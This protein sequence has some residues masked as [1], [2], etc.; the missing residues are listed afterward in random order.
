MNYGMEGYGLYWYCL[1]EIANSVSQD[2]YT[3]ELEQDSEILAFDTGLSVT[4]IEEMMCYI[5]KLGLFENRE[6]V[7]S[8]LKMAKRLDA[9]MTS[10]PEMR[11]IIT[12]LK[13]HDPVMTQSCESHD[14]VKKLSVT[15]KIRL[16][17][18]R[19]KGRFTPPT[20]EEVQ[21]YLNEKGITHFTGEQFVNHY[22]SVNWF[23]GKSKIKS[24]KHCVGTWNK[25]QPENNEEVIH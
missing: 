5:V 3:F 7:I 10:N 15:D 12:R 20:S 24:W 11:N 23:R 21:K 2:K 17:E 13:N 1:E 14:P 6:G 8:C 9:S 25:N 18:K 16:E 4:K 22:A 19:N